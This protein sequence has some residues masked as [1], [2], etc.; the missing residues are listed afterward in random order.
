M[1]QI[2]KILVSKTGKKFY[3]R[4]GQDVH[5][6]FGVIKESD[7]LSAKDGSEISSNTGEGFHL[8]SPTFMD[9][10]RK[11]KR[12]PQIIPLKDISAIIAETGI[13]KDSEIVEAGSGSGGSSCFFGHMAKK[14][15]TYENRD[16]FAE[17]AEKNIAFLGLDN[18]TLKRKNIY[19]GIDEKDV[20]LILFDLPDPW[21]GIDIAKNALKVGGYLVSYSPTTPQLSDF[22]E[23]SRKHPEFR[24]IKIIEVSE[25]EWEAKE[26]KVRPKSQSIGHSGFLVFLRK[27][28]NSS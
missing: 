21:L 9:L 13:N 11:I 25:R 8:I 15:T 19:E 20:D 4:K 28:G 6:Q 17:I 23:E 22:S 10:Y 2:E 3:Y 18:V 12:G 5:T 14:V 16:E 7:I 1:A 24:L 27:I 26:R